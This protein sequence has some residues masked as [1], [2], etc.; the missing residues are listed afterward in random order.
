[1]FL[2]LQASLQLVDDRWVRVSSSLLRFGSFCVRYYRRVETLLFYLTAFARHRF[3]EA[4]RR[5][6]FIVLVLFGRRVRFEFGNLFR[7]SKT[8]KS[9]KFEFRMK[10]EYS[11]SHPAAFYELARPTRSRMIF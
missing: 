5:D 10:I 8:R 11:H 3:F 2:V 4:R 6:D 7:K 9:K 1:M